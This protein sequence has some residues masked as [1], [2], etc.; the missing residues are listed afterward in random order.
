MYQGDA[1]CFEEEFGDSIDKIKNGIL[2][3]VETGDMEVG[4][5]FGDVL[6]MFTRLK[7]RGFFEE[8]E[9][10]SVAC[11]MTKEI[12]EEYKSVDPT[13][14]SPD[15][16]LKTIHIREDG[17]PYIKMFDFDK[18]TPLP[19]TRIIVGPKNNQAQSKTEIENLV[20]RSVEIHCSETPLLWPSD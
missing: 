1:E 13:Y 6:S 20:G 4:E 14:V 15:M 11:P 16:P 19:I 8:R 3:F 17:A 18:K 9:V 7:H 2:E 12:E 10:R 5:I